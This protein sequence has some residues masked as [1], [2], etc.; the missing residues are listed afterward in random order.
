MT[1]SGFTMMD[2]P[3]ITKYRGRFSNSGTGEPLSFAESAELFSGYLKLNRRL[4][5]IARI[6]D[7]YQGEVK[8]LVFELQ[9]A[10]ARVLE[11]KGCIPICASCKKIRNDEGYWKHLEQFMSE[12]SEALFSH[13]LCPDCVSN[14]RL[15][16]RKTGADTPPSNL[17][18]AHLLNETDLDDPVILKFLP[19]LNQKH[20]AS[21]PLYDEFSSLFQ[22]YIRL[23]KRLKRIIRISDS[24]QSQLQELKNKL[25]LSS[26]TDY[27]TELSNRRD[28]YDKLESE[29]SRS[30]R[31]NKRFA[32]VMVDF[33][34][35]KNI[36]DT[37]GHDVGDRVLIA[38]ARI[39][40][41][42]VRKEDS[43]ARW[44]GEEFLLLLPE[45]D[46]KNAL[47]VAE[48]LRELIAGLSIDANGTEIR[49]TVSLGISIVTPEETLNN[50]IKR[51]DEAL[52][53]AKKA[54]RNRS[55]LHE[56]T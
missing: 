15:F 29:F 20:F 9:D 32:I 2:D 14:Y 44:G 43:C 40:K 49:T 13:G 42:H 53:L 46:G 17:N 45:T 47:E 50:C 52:F 51:S 41:A 56:E 33:D 1:K 54:G 36:N 30:L 38:A 12:H 22:K 28:M 55:V 7:N 34:H 37:Y 21:S 3:I 27:L 18:P 4:A 16:S 5:R 19:I 31:H 10:S 11:L 6:S 48:K 26:R 23:T 39:F 35:F 8:S 24:F 25:E